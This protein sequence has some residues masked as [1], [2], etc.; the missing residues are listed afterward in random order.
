MKMNEGVCRWVCINVAV[1]L[2]AGTTS[3]LSEKATFI[4]ER[5]HVHFFKF[6]RRY[7]K[8]ITI[9]LRLSIVHAFTVQLK[10]HK[11]TFFLNSE[12]QCFEFLFSRERAHVLVECSLSD[13]NETFKALLY[14]YLLLRKSRLVPLQQ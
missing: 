4:F 14:F 10:V 1:L 11:F 9:F 5:A 12:I 13:I 2:P 6:Y 7:K 3:L 8:L